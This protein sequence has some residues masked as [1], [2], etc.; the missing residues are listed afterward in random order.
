[1]CGRLLHE[2]RYCCTMPDL[3]SYWKTRY[4]WNQQQMELLDLTGTKTAISKLRGAKAK[5][6][7]KLRC[8]WLPV[9]DRQARI[10]RD[11]LA[12]CSACSSTGLVVETIDHIFQC[13]G[14][15]RRKAVKEKLELLRSKL[16]EWG[17]APQLRDAILAGISAWIVGDDIPDLESLKVSDDA[18]GDHIREAYS[19]QI[20]LGW[21]VFIRGFWTKSWRL[22]QEEYWAR[23]GK[24]DPFATGESWSGKVQGW[25]F[26]FVSYVWDLRNAAE[27]GE[28]VHAQRQIRL[29]QCERT[30]R[31]LYARSL[32]LPDGETYPFR[33]PI[34]TLL[35]RP[36]NDQE[37][38]IQKTVPF[39]RLA[40]RRAKKRN[41]TKQRAITEFFNTVRGALPG[42]DLVHA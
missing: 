3:L 30:I 40:F 9:N 11:Q 16:S 34:Q 25:F 22:A 5:L 32:D 18:V 20:S 4:L 29:N 15:S 31:R 1:M 35:D 39:L 8:G 41:K 10:E 36:V 13:E 2:L 42:P 27:H 26:D 19:E 21:N 33:E 28:D 37:L 12:G 38:W 6:I 23:T 24:P 17:T 7:Q 14:A